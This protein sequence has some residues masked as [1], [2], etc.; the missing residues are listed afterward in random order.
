MRPHAKRERRLR[1][2]PRPRGR[3]PKEVPTMNDSSTRAPLGTAP[4]LEVYNKA[5]GTRSYR[6]RHRVD[7]VQRA[8]AIAARS[9]TEA[10]ALAWAILAKTER[11]EMDGQTVLDLLPIFLERTRLAD[12][13]KGLYESRIR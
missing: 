8:V 10:T 9:D 3:H 4:G 12:S 7:G 5:D 6:L 2:Q 1:K 13:T 11:G